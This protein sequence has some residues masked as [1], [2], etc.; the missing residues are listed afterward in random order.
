MRLRQ[1]HENHEINE[2][3]QPM[4]LETEFNLIAGDLPSAPIT[5]EVQITHIILYTYTYVICTNTDSQKY[6]WEL[7]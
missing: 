7:K 5:P 3:V 4:G 1:Q 2:A 6:W